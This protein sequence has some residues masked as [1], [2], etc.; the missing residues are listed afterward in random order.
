MWGGSRIVLG[1]PGGCGQDK[2]ADIT[3]REH[4]RQCQGEPDGTNFVAVELLILEDGGSPLSGV[5][6]HMQE[7]CQ[8]R[9][10]LLWTSCVGGG[11]ARLHYASGPRHLGDVLS[12][13]RNSLFCYESVSSSY[14]LF[15]FL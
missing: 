5:L 3:A 1:S 10:L 12:I 9:M 8:L 6:K 14:T 7:S 11:R 15:L 13:T 2:Q 4:L